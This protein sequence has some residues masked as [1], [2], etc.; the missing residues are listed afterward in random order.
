MQD[1]EECRGIQGNK[2]T[3]LRKKYQLYR[4]TYINMY[5]HEHD[6]VDVQIVYVN[7]HEIG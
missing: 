4:I 3:E 5:R 2:Y 6:H 7:E 1:S